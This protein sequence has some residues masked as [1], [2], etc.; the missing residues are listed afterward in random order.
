V[1]NLLSHGK[2]V[3]VH[4]CVYVRA[5]AERKR[6]SILSASVKEYSTPSLHAHAREKERT[7]YLYV[8][9]GCLR[10]VGSLKL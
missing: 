5:R 4:A 3:R 2:C 1:L 7:L 8:S 6:E 9:M 10:L